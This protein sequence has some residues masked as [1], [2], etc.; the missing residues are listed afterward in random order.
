M[1]QQDQMRNMTN[2]IEYL[3][4]GVYAGID[5]ATGQMM[6]WTGNG[7]LVRDLIFFEPAAWQAAKNY[8]RK[9][10]EQHLTPIGGPEL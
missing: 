2:N 5:S 7:R 3:A 8:A 10:F 6:L 1:T 4:D 9:Y